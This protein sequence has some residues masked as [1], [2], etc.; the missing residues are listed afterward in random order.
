MQQHNAP[1]AVSDAN[2]LI[3]L[4]KTELIHFLFELDISIHTTEVAFEQLT[5]KQQT[6]ISKFITGPHIIS[7]CTAEELVEIAKLNFPTGLEHTDRTLFYYA[8]K[9]NAILIVGDNKFHSYCLSQSL[10]VEDIFWL[11]DTFVER[12]LIDETTAIA[13]LK[14]LMIINPRLQQQKCQLK[15]NEWLK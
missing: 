4:L 7:T 14:K 5:L 15:I 13:G 11:L 3:D 8:Q 1:I 9:H 6:Q 10:K 12:K 2:I